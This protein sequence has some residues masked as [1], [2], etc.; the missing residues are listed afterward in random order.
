MFTAFTAVTP[1][2]FTVRRVAIGI[3]QETTVPHNNTNAANIFRFFIRASFKI[4]PLS[5]RKRFET[6]PSDLL[7][8][9]Q[10]LG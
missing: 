8:D 6:P 7:R 2:F 5:S 4:P 1:A 9:R 10:K 3:P